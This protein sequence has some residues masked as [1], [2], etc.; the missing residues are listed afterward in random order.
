MLN[1]D[2]QQSIELS[3]VIPMFN[4]GAHIIHAIEVITASVKEVTEHYEL[5][6]VDDGSSDDTWEQLQKATTTIPNVYALRLSRNFGKEY[7]LCAGLEKSK[8]QAVIVMDADLQHPP[9]LI[10]EM[11]NVWRL[12]KAGVVECVKRSRGKES[13][14]YRASAG[15]FYRMLKSITGYDLHGASD[16]K[17]L[18]RK[19]VQAWTTLPEK[20]TFFRGMTAWL[21]FKK[22]R[23][24]FDVDH[25]VGGETKWSVIKLTKLALNAIVSFTS[26]PLRIVTFAGALFFFAAVILAGQTLYHKWIGSAV[27]GFTTVIILQ[28]IIG[29]VIMLSLGIIGEYISA[30]YNEVKGRPRYLIQE[31]A[32]SES[33]REASL[34]EGAQHNTTV[35]EYVEV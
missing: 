35:K 26:L 15:L 3:V 16:F 12:E 17:L 9:K 14:S 10:P 18:D 20:R 5:I 33:L 21:G 29:S 11:V 8:G 32:A 7:A 22:V 24:E 1:K 27:T 28:L 19:V 4:E 34:H 6:L 25:R 2:G 30:I 23:I 31:T 13:L